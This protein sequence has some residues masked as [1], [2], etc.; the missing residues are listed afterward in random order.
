V[1]SADVA[2]LAYALEGFV[3]DL[4]AASAAGKAARDFARAHFALDRFLTEWDDLI[5]ECLG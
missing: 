4:A 2:T 3:T 1:V 5:E